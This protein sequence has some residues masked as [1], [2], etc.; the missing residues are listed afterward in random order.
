MSNE[1]YMNLC[2]EIEPFF[3]AVATVVNNLSD[4]QK[5]EFPCPLCGRTAFVGKAAYNGHVHAWC[6]CG[7]EVRQ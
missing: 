6:D 2:E 5:T 7:A 4:G 1:E 3:K